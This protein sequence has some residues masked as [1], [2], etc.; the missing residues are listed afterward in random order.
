MIRLRLASFDNGVKAPLLIDTNLNSFDFS[1]SVSTCTKCVQEAGPDMR[2]KASSLALSRGRGLSPGN[3]ASRESYTFTQLVSLDKI[4]VFTEANGTSSSSKALS[5][6]FASEHSSLPAKFNRK[7]KS[8]NEI[9]EKKAGRGQ[10][11][12]DFKQLKP[13]NCRRSD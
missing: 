6:D 8:N 13:T 3:P 12:L 10:A 2:R 1:H 11:E 4:V 5:L 7:T 9:Y